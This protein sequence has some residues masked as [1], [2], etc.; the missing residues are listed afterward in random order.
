MVCR[1]EGFVWCLLQVKAWR[2]AGLFGTGLWLRKEGGHG[3]EKVEW[4]IEGVVDRFSLESWRFGC[5]SFG[6]LLCGLSRWLR[7]EAVR[8]LKE[9]RQR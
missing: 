4:V 7:R 8:C 6:L 5:F 1:F 3:L 9:W 2:F